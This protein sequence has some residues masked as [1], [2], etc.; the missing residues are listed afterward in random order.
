MTLGEYFEIHNIFG[1]VI[2]S[3]PFDKLRVNSGSEE[4]HFLTRFPLKI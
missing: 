3:D 4:S 1:H 2:L